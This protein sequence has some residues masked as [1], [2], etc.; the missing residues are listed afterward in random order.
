MPPIDSHWNLSQYALGT[1]LIECA[2]IFKNLFGDPEHMQEDNGEMSSFIKIKTVQNT[3]CSQEPHTALSKNDYK[4][5]SEYISSS[6]L[7]KSNKTILKI[8][9]YAD[10]TIQNLMSCMSYIEAANA[11]RKVFCT[12]VGLYKF[13]YQNYL[14]IPDCIT[15]YVNDRFVDVNRTAG[16]VD[17]FE[18]RI[19]P[20]STIKKFSSKSGIMNYTDSGYRVYIYR[21][22][23]L[24]ELMLSSLVSLLSNKFYIL[25]CNHC[26][27]YFLSKRRNV[28]YCNGNSKK[29]P[30][31]SCRVQQRIDQQRV[32]DSDSIMQQHKTYRTLL[33]RRA[34]KY[35]PTNYTIDYYKFNKSEVDINYQISSCTL[36]LFIDYTR[37]I[38]RDVKNG[39]RS[40]D[41][42][43]EWMKS[44]YNGRKDVD[45]MV[46]GILKS[47]E[48]LDVCSFIQSLYSVDSIYET[49]RNFSPKSSNPN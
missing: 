15:S 28:K 16:Y 43:L 21:I 41:Y 19:E 12:T 10:M 13:I 26:G 47:D 22:I 40:S 23:E 3:L 45:M 9:E 4:C 25:K 2:N 44:Y 7:N 31:N 33:A 46:W 29:H 8:A 35:N 27:D 39:I 37:I 14:H 30:L 17:P 20:I 18:V 11:E 34:A 1:Y 42:Y 49:L 24:Y 38:R 5:V 6:F 36:R 32:L 48:A